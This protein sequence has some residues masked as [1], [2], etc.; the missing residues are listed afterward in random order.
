M[1]TKDINRGDL[2]FTAKA[3]ISINKDTDEFTS[4]INDEIEL[5]KFQKLPKISKSRNRKKFKILK[6]KT[7]E[8]NLIDSEH[9]IA[10]G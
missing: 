7:G 1:A 4:D 3:F 9:C 10:C 8:V 6:A 5:E 2:I